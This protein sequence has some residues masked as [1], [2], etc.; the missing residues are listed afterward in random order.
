M[1][2]YNLVWR[3]QKLFAAPGA[4]KDMQVVAELSGDLKKRGFLVPTFTLDEF[5][6]FGKPW[7]IVVM[8][9]ADELGQVADV[10]LETG[11][12]DPK[13]NAIVVKAM[14]RGK[15]QGAAPGRP[16]HR[17]GCAELWPAVKSDCA[18]SGLDLPPPCLIHSA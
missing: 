12:D 9:E 2:G 5:E 3:A 8:I 10:I 15:I 1:G 18:D 17:P 7:Q 14:Y 6:Q 13:I 11:C 16:P 4:S